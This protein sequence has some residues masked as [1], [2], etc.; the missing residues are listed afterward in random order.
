MIRA[1]AALLMAVAMPVSA[2][3]TDG[4]PGT[5]FVSVEIDGSL[6]LR[7]G[8]TTDSERLTRLDNGTLLRR[9]ECQ[10]G[11]EEDWCEVETLDGS[12]E[13]WVAVRFLRPQPR[14]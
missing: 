3:E 6:N 5:D 4:F 10:P 14:R 8:P 7:A 9:V 11:A 1:F 13:G 2:Q 12:L